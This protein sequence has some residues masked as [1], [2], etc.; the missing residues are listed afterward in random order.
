[1]NIQRKIKKL[2][3]QI[4]SLKKEIQ[5]QIQKEKSIEQWF[6]SLLNGLEVEIKDDGPDPIL[7]Y[8]KNS[9]VFFELHQAFN[10]KEKKYFWCDPE[11]VWCA[12]ENEY[13]LNYDEIQVV[14]KSLVKKYLKLEVTVL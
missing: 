2:E 8:K 3:N 14:I 9:K 1:M 11:L 4:K 10:N 13:N 5:K 6:K 12:L 7:Y